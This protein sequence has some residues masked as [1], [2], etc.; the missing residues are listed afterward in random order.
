[1]LADPDTTGKS[2]TDADLDT[3]R[4][5]AL[6]Y[7]YKKKLAR[8][9]ANYSGTHTAMTLADTTTIDFALPTNYIRITDVQY[10]FNASTTY[11]I[12]RSSTWDDRVRP[13][14][15]R[16]FDAPDY[17]GYRI[18]LTGLRKWS[19]ID[20]SLMPDAVYDVCM[21]AAQVFAVQSFA[22]KRSAQRRNL[23]SAEVTLGS[24]GVWYA[25]LTAQLRTDV[26]EARQ[27]MRPIGV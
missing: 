2:F 24:E 27:A 20:D 21:T 13:G 1:M 12:G 23:S 6:R 25:R 14:Y 16:I 7:L 26:K 19:G 18:H 22:N 3:F 9:V 11:P 17:S 10:W 15:I 5:K 8:E 4:D